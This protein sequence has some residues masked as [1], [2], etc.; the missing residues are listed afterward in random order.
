MTTSPRRLA[1][2]IVL[3]SAIP[4]AALGWL[5]WRLLEM[6]ETF[7]AQRQREQLQTAA[8]ASVRDRQRAI[9]DWDNA[10]TGSDTLAGTA[11]LEFDSHGLVSRGGIRLPYY[12]QGPGASQVT[13]EL[14]ARAEAAEF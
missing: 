11:R 5:G 14:F 7:Q 4:V 8:D 12:P 2:L 6:D 9:G 10:L 13:P 3:L 1:L